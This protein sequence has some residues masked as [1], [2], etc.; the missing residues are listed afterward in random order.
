[1]T[2]ERER[3]ADDLLLQTVFVPKKERKKERDP[4]W[5]KRG[6]G[7]EDENLGGYGISTLHATWAFF[8]YVSLCTTTA[9]WQHD[10]PA[11][12]SFGIL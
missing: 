5:G 3:E 12:G 10:N 8:M 4:P 11:A 2:R 6:G 9:K 1:M 7:R